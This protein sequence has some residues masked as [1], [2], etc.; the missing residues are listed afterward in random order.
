MEATHVHQESTTALQTLYAEWL[1]WG[2]R[3]GFGTL[4]AAG[5]LYF[6]GLVPA[7]VPLDHL[8]TLWSLPADRFREVAHFPTGWS[9]LA[10]I[11]YPDILPFLGIA[12]LAGS[13][14]LCFARTAVAA[15][16]SGERFFATI[17]LLVAAVIL[18]SASGII[19]LRH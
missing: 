1:K 7:K 8:V 4:V 11:R 19:A 13:P 5:V 10:E 9:W 12:F 17:S 6:F 14:I 18:A 3:L 2:F 15:W 16:Q